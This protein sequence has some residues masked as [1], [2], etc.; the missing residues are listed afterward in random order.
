MDGAILACTDPSVPGG[1]AADWAASEARLH[2]L[3]LR[4]TAGSPPDAGRAKM[5]VYDISR[6]MP[7]T[8]S[9]LGPGP[10][11]AAEAMG[12]PLVFVPDRHTS[13]YRAGQI[14]LGVDARDPGGPAVEFA[15]DEARVRKARLHAVHAWTL[16]PEAREWPFGPPEQDRA[17]WEDHE[18]QLLADALRPWREKFPEVPVLEDVTLLTPARALLHHSATATLL[19]VGRRPAAGRDGVVRAIVGEAL[20]PVAVVTGSDAAGRPR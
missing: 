10:L 1:S 9:P 6:D 17:S 2:G 12:R 8:G 16:P 4:V 13:T 7:T 14:V 5:I 18:V 20:C 19:V 15:F 3:P 11:V